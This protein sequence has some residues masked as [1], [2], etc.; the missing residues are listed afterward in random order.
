MEPAQSLET[1]QDAVNPAPDVAGLHWVLGKLLQ[2]P[3]DK[4]GAERRKFW[5]RLA[6]EVRPLLM[7]GEDG[8]RYLLPAEKV[9]EERKNSENPELYAVFPFRVFGVGK[10]SLGS[11]SRTWKSDGS[12]SPDVR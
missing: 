2:L 8:R 3:E 11:A 5:G 12:P 9:L 1:W 4:A 7:A 10:P 6:G